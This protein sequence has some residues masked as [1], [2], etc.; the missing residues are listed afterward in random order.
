MDDTERA[1][2]LQR[3]NSLEEELEA[4]KFKFNE[5][6]NLTNTGLW[7]WRV[8]DN[9]VIWTDKVY[10]IFDFPLGSDVTY[11]RLCER[12]HPEDLETH[13]Q[14]TRQWIESQNCEPFEY[15]LM[16]PDGLIKYVVAHGNVICDGSGEVTKLYGAVRDVTHEVLMDNHRQALLS[17][18]I[19]GFIPICSYCKSVRDDKNQ[20]HTLESYLHS[21]GGVHLSHGICDNCSNHLK[22]D[23][24]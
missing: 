17:R 24:S 4:F 10:E 1:E 6:Q 21:K 23:A 9:E 14:L 7:E 18:V 11:E 12:I 22:T 20:W 16:M 3:I 2:L 13:H 19:D 5:S 8:A 15:R